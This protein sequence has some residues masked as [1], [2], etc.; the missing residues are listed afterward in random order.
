[1]V[2][3]VAV[4]G[5]NTRK[6]LPRKRLEAIG[7]GRRWL[8]FFRASLGVAVNKQNLN[9]KWMRLFGDVSSLDCRCEKSIETELEFFLCLGWIIFA[10]FP[11]KRDGAKSAHHPSRPWKITYI[12]TEL[13]P[14]SAAAVMADD[15]TARLGWAVM[16]GRLELIF[17]FI[18]RVGWR[19]SW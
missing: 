3:M 14:S 7:V 2:R 1:M 16:V 18:A 11:R 9:E 17:V 13:S 8:G 6:I 15:S 12:F 10:H 4:P 19:K 5:E